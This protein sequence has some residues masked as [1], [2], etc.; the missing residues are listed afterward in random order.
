MLA[1]GTPKRKPIAVQSGVESNNDTLHKPTLAAAT[2]APPANDRGGLSGKSDQRYPC[3]GKRAAEFAAQQPKTDAPDS[4]SIDRRSL[5]IGGGALAVAAGSYQLWANANLPRAAVFVARHQRYDGP[6]ATT[7]RD[8]LL[9]TG[10][11]PIGSAGA[12]R[13]AKAELG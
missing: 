7:I 9:A 4:L 8:G 2:F 1:C 12:A 10:S 3:G 5:L 6:L 13:V 11:M